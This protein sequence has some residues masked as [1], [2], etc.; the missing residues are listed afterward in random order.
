MKYENNLS[1]LHRLLDIVL[2]LVQLFDWIG[3]GLP[4][5]LAL[6]RGFRVT[7]NE[8]TGIQ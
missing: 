1:L 4:K 3:R 7:K 6:G 5:S 2:A 8:G